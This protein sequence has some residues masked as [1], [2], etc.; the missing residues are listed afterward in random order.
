LRYN[1]EQRFNYPQEVGAMFSSFSNS[2][3]LVKASWAVLRSDKELV[4][5]PI[6][7][8]ITMIILTIVFLIPAAV[9]MGLFAAMS[10]PD[11]V[12][13][14]NTGEGA[15]SIIGYVILFL[16]YLVGYTV[17]Y[18][19]QTALVGAAMIRLDGGDPTVR[20]GFRIANSRIGIIIQYAL[21]SST[22][23]LILS[24]IRDQGWL[25]RLAA[26]LLDFAW[27]VATFLVVPILAVKEIGPIDAIKES[28]ALLKKTW[29]EQ[30]VASFGIGTVSGLA[31]F[32]VIL[33]GGGLTVALG[34]ALNSGFIFVVGFVLVFA[35]VAIIGVITSA[36]NGIYQAALYRYAETGVAPDNFDI[37]MI[38]G[39]FHTKD[40]R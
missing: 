17:S 25:G 16:F 23:G 40:K 29:G 35:L 39:A 36:L 9:L 14:S 30:L 37:D 22:V 21:I 38:R 32:A 2:W 31:I 13:R 15:G 7:S 19:F 3:Q 18:Y 6:I 4:L 1:I 33:I 10:S 12:S 26:S 27:N 20:D 34:S 11:A 28:V 24:W 8:S 5:F